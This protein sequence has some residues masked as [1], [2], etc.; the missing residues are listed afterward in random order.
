MIHR[1][2]SLPSLA[3]LE[4]PVDGYIRVSRVG[5]R[6]GESYISPDIQR[7]ALEAWAAERGVELVVHEPE[8]NVSGGT[9][10][11]PVFNRIM[12]RIRAKESGGIVV[13]KLDRFARTGDWRYDFRVLLIARTGP[14]TEA[15][16]VMRFVRE[17]EMPEEAREVVQTIVRTRSIAVQN[18]GRY[19]PGGVSFKVQEGLGWPFTIT[20]HTSAWRHFEA[21][22]PTDTDRPELTDE[23]YCVWDEPHGDYLYT[24]A[25]VKKLIKD[26]KDPDT[27][28]DITGRRPPRSSGG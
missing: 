24:E 11:R 19:K 18:K 14:K 23:R 17:D 26:L 9:M 10:D 1:A 3:D 28:E 4:L 8:E 25:W 5:D 15:D 7:N 6:S 2:K 20:D 12:R 16:A 27:H 21:R 13:Y 22:P